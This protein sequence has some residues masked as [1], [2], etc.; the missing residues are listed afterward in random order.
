[1]VERGMRTS[2]GTGDQSTGGASARHVDG[3]VSRKLRKKTMKIGI[4]FGVSLKESEGEW[5]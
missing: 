3:F 1:M 2:I 4:H 5:R